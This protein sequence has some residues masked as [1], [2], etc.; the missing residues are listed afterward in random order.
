MPL[1]N[2]GPI[3]VS[4]L[5]DTTYAAPLIF[6]LSGVN[7]NSANTD[8]AIPISVPTG[9][10]RYLVISCRINGASG[11]LNSSTFGLFTATGGG[12]FAAVASG[13]AGTITTASENTLNNAASLTV[14]N[15]A[16]QSYQVA[17]TPILYFRVQTPQ[18]SAATA[19]VTIQIVPL[20]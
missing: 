15:S 17:T 5:G 1:F 6:A 18:G 9:F 13:T 20:P 4:R 12:G 10:T 7:F 16:N 14:V 19:S 3:S 2:N 8:H 11:A